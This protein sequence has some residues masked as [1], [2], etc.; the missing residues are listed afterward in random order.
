MTL[1]ELIDHIQDKIYTNTG[2]NISGN[3]L[4]GVLLT[5]VGEMDINKVLAAGDSLSHKIKASAFFSDKNATD[6][7]QMQDILDAVQELEIGDYAKT[8]DISDVT[9]TIKSG[10]LELGNITLNQSTAGTID[11]KDAI[12]KIVDA[13]TSTDSE[14]TLSAKQ[15]KV[16]MDLID[17]L[18]TV[19]SSGLNLIDDFDA[20]AET[21]FP[22]GTETTKG[23]TWPVITSGTVHG[24]TI[25]PGD[26]IIAR[27]SN[28]SKTS[29]A[30][31]IFI[32]RNI[33][34]ATE[35]KAG[36]I[37]IATQAEVNAGSDDSTAVTP[38]KLDKRLDDYTK[39]DDLPTYTG[40]DGVDITDMTVSLTQGTRDD[41]SKGVEAHGYGLDDAVNNGSNTN[42]NIST[43]TRNFIWKK[44]NAD[45]TINIG[46]GD[47]IFILLT[48]NEGQIRMRITG[49]IT[50]HRGDSRLQ[51]SALIDF[52]ISADYLFEASDV[53]F[54]CLIMGSLPRDGQVFSD[55]MKITIGED[56]FLGFSIDNATSPYNEFYFSGY[57]TENVMK[58][59]EEDEVDSFEE[60]Q[61]YNQNPLIKNS[62]E[63][64]YKSD[65][66][67]TTYSPGTK[68]DI[69]NEDEEKKVW[70]GKTLKSLAPI[71]QE[72]EW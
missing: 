42:Q 27:K 49:R 65:L 48:K 2:R 23:D 68:S 3:E 14:K 62:K 37:R 19:T 32:Q 69:D 24:E 44:L 59:V 50:A 64:A 63:I 55:L 45:Y 4:Q 56:E 40:T 43:Y 25:E 11:I 46:N 18:Q 51:G 61:N 35:T 33:D 8:E 26:M 71:W 13:L 66:Q 20:G 57:D 7:A 9:I 60:V 31:W 16:L 72:N 5:I 47:K 22:G 17:D 53:Q 15:G 34:K 28:P 67:D 10:S 30:D 6:L 58:V 21:D 29:G 70:D 52:S 36:Y 12:P 38:Q 39:T 1:Q 54:D 41:I